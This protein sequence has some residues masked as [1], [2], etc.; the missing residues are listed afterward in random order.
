MSETKATEE[1]TAVRL[2]SLALA[3]LIWLAVF[4]E[5]PAEVKLSMPL[6]LQQVP[7]RLKVVAAPTRVV[8]VTVLGPRIL[9]V[10]PLL[11]GASAV[12]DLEQAQPGPASY[13]AQDCE[14]TLDTELKVVRVH[15]AAFRVDLAAR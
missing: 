9:L 14:F 8:E 1:L 6:L 4:L 13:G 7:P 15:P 5:R 2:F 10:R 3:G 11:F 12:L